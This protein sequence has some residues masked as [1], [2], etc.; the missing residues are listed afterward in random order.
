VTREGLDSEMAG[1]EE[2]RKRETRKVTGR[3]TSY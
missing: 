2:N 1:E 3:R